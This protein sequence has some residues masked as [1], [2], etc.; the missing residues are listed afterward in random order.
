MNYLG[1][2]RREV[3]NSLFCSP[4]LLDILFHFIGSCS[5]WV[6][7][8]QTWSWFLQACLPGGPENKSLSLLDPTHSSTGIEDVGLSSGPNPTLALAQSR[9]KRVGGNGRPWY[10]EFFST[11][12][13]IKR[14][15]F[16]PRSSKDL[17]PGMST[18]CPTSE[19]LQGGQAV[20]PPKFSSYLHPL[21]PLSRQQAQATAGCAFCHLFYFP[22]GPGAQMR[23]RR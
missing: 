11:P 9:G 7:C 13:C 21:P 6:C 14:V 8:S 23:P 10:S 20:P 17:V 18:I 5:V 19:R 16:G 1:T 22:N 3:E 2:G 4:S 15:D 12:A